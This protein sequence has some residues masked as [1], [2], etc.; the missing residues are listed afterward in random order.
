LAMNNKGQFDTLI[1]VGEYFL[2]L[3]VKIN[4]KKTCKIEVLHDGKVVRRPVLY[5]KYVNQ[6]KSIEET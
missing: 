2:L 6:F 4:D 5:T 1:H 3:N